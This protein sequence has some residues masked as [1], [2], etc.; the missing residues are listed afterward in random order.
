MKAALVLTAFVLAAG[1]AWPAD[2]PGSNPSVAAPTVQDR[3]A[4]ARKAVDRKDWSAAQRELTVLVREA[5]QNADAHNLLGYTYRKRSSPDMAKAYQHYDM[6]LKIDPQHKGA[7]EY[8]GEAY[9]VDKRLPDAERQLAEL[10][11]ICG[12]PACEEYRDLA[13]S[14]AD[15]KAK[16]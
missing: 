4:T 13:K 5:P 3:L 10:E 14:I 6:A 9:L 8:L 15:Y 7:R 16:Q 12:G 1:A 11:K 2:T